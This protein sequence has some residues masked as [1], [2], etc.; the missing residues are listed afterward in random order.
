[1]ENRVPR[2]DPGKQNGYKSPDKNHGLNEF[3]P[4]FRM[5][6]S[7]ILRKCGDDAEVNIL[8]EST[9]DL[10]DYTRN[11]ATHGSARCDAQN[12]DS[13]LLAGGIL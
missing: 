4:A 9:F 3:V 8:R 2:K 7:R 12:L 5:A 1:V 13:V 11:P 6:A 10:F